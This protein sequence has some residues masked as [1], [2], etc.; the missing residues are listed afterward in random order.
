MRFNYLSLH[1]SDHKRGIRDLL[2]YAAPR[3]R[4]YIKEDDEE[5]EKK[6]SGYLCKCL[7]SYFE[8]YSDDSHLGIVKCCYDILLRHYEIQLNDVRKELKRKRDRESFSTEEE[9]IL[10]KR[11]QEVCVLLSCA[12]MMA[13]Y[14]DLTER[15]IGLP[16]DEDYPPP[17]PLSIQL[18]VLSPQSGRAIGIR[19]MGVGPLSQLISQYCNER[20]SDS[21]YLLQSQA[22][23]ESC[24][25]HRQYQY[26]ANKERQS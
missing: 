13:M 25:R 9:R 7:V 24:L 22:L 11:D 10:R 1:L 17:A 8:I 14:G 5:R 6:S 21:L 16:D 15:P 12:L 2:T 3:R 20:C 4:R 19:G 23:V 18:N 26:H